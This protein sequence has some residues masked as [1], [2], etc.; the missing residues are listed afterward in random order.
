MRVAEQNTDSDNLPETVPGTVRGAGALATLEGAVGVVIAIVLI[1]QGATSEHDSAFSAYGTAAWFLILAGAV[2]AAGIG[3]LRGKRWGRAIV[4]IAQILLLP[5]AW[6]MLSSHRFELGIPVG[7]VALVTL[8]L[9]FSPPS[10]RWMAQ[11]YD[12]AD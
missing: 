9:V 7:L 12:V 5:A 2:L 3:L 4:V 10:V 1:V 11:A 6:Y 8:G